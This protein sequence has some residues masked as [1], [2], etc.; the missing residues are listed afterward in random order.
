MSSKT[1]PKCGRAYPDEAQICEDC[2]EAL[3]AVEE[4]APVRAGELVH[5]TTVVGLA[6]A[7]ILTN[8]LVAEGI[9]ALTEDLTLLTLNI[10]MGEVAAGAGGVRVLVNSEDAEAALAILESHRRGELAL[11]DEDDEPGPEIT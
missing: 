2:D 3:V 10:T 7:M 6:E 5:L 1:C 8:V 11:S 9:R 4:S